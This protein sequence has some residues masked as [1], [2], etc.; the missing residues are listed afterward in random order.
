MNLQQQLRMKRSEKNIKVQQKNGA[1]VAAAA[2]ASVA[3][4]TVFIAATEC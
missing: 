3:S 4:T 1:N 2:A